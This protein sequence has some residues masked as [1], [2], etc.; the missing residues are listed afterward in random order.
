MTKPIITRKFIIALLCIFIFIGIF[1]TVRLYMYVQASQLQIVEIIRPSDSTLLQKEFGIDLLSGSKITR[2]GYCEDRIVVR[3]EG[4][5]DLDTFLTGSLHLELD[6]EEAQKLSDHIYHLVNEK[7][8]TFED[9]YG[10]ERY[11]SGFYISEYQSNR[12]GDLA[13]ADFFLIDGN[14]VVEISNT[15]FVTVNRARFREIVNQ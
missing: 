5:D 1:F 14:L 9:M 6:S 10:N 8:S 3:I 7:N 11:F 13:R 15:Y 12:S 4:I 2:F